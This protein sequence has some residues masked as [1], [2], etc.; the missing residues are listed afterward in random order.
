MI[1]TATPAPNDDTVVVYAPALGD[2]R[3]LEALLES[4]GHPVRLCTDLGDFTA[5]LDGPVGLLVFSQEAFTPAMMT[6]LRDWLT[7]QEAWSE[8][9][10]LALLDPGQQRLS[11]ST[12]LGEAM[13][14]AGLIMLERPVRATEFITAAQSLI[15]G[16]RRQFELRDQLLHQADLLRELNHRV[17]N[18]LAN[19]YAVYRMTYRN[20]EDLEAFGH[21]FEAR[22]LALSRVHEMLTSA[23]WH[24]AD[25]ATLAKGALEPFGSELGS[26]L[27]GEP[28][29]EP[30]GAPVRFTL[31]GPRVSLAPRQALNVALT[32]HELA[33]NASEHGAFSTA[34]GRVDLSWR[35]EEGELLTLHWVERNGPE[36]AAPSRS[37]FGTAFI[38]SA[39]SSEPRGGATFD[40]RPAGLACELTLKLDAPHTT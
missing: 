11:R 35:L 5:A 13:P 10:V 3:A 2:G 24:S 18:A 20:S 7:G 8:P 1:T 17:K 31:N 32:L 34:D 4:E 25:L 12:L 37:G 30:G 36:G 38:R 29:S 39:F 9:P 6:A 21:A 23:D 22:L 28:G 27:G 26:E 15:A 33:T 14:R 16:R 19:V 40:F